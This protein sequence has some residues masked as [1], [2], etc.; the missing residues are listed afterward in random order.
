MVNPDP[1][2]PEERTQRAEDLDFLSRDA[3]PAPRAR[4]RFS[5]SPPCCINPLALITPPRGPGMA[6]V[7]SR[8]VNPLFIQTIGQTLDDGVLLHPP[9]PPSSLSP[10]T[11]QS[12]TSPEYVPPHYTYP[13]LD[14]CVGCGR[15][16]NERLF[17]CRPSDIAM[18]RRDDVESP[19]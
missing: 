12:S 11:S 3:S 18:E 4:L 16:G 19:D 14:I 10:T 6:M 5:P 15:R 17:R 8:L 9:N 7:D 2:T 1:M 13:I